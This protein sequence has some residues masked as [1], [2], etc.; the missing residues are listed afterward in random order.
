MY[1][2]Q[3]KPRLERQTFS[4]Y[5]SFFSE[6]GIY[7]GA[8]DIADYVSFF[9]N[10]EKYSGA[11]DI[12][13]SDI[14]APLVTLNLHPMDTGI[15]LHEKPTLLLNDSLRLAKRKLH[16]I[17]EVFREESLFPFLISINRL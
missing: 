5:V 2:F 15:L 8:S 6:F 3:L 13:D 16:L 1:V 11:S 4:N 9:R 12:A 17:P 7:S 14:R 10:S